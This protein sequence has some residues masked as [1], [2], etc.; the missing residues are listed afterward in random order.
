MENRCKDDVSIFVSFKADILSEKSLYFGK[1]L[2]AKQELITRAR[3]RDKTLRLARISLLISAIQRV[4]RF[5]SG[6]YFIKAIK[7]FFPVFA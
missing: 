4:L 5:F 3:P 7:N 6:I 1:N 2:F